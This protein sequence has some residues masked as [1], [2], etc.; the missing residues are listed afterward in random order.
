MTEYSEEEKKERER[1]ISSIESIM[2][3]LNEMLDEPKKPHLKVV[4]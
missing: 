3:N 2:K 1:L 4:K